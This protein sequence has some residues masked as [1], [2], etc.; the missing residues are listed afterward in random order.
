MQQINGN[1]SHCHWSYWRHAHS[2]IVASMPILQNEFHMRKLTSH[3]YTQKSL[4]TKQNDKSTHRINVFIDTEKYS[5]FS[6]GII[7]FSFI[8]AEN[9]ASAHTPS[10]VDWWLPT[11]H[12]RN[13]SN[14]RA[15]RNGWS[16]V[17]WIHESLTTFTWALL[18]CFNYN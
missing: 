10:L 3:S 17:Q 13:C 6:K 7:L 8:P 4:G 2:H 12:I 18:F 16:F 11:R 14:I 9:I 5:D 1:K 15:I